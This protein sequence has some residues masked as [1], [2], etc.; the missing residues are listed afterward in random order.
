MSF[1]KSSIRHIGLVVED[2][3]SSKDFW[4]NCIGLSVLKEGLESGKFLDNMMALNNVE[5]ETCKLIDENGMVLELLF[6]HSH[7]YK[8]RDKEENL[9]VY[10]KGF[11]HIALETTNIDLLIKNLEQYNCKPLNDPMKSPDGLV[12]V[13][14]SVGPEN[15]LLELVELQIKN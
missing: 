8:S 5:V 2:L 7:K 3:E 10:K 1:V 12:R 9:I 6:F 13:T 4:I 11:T 15:I 14:Y